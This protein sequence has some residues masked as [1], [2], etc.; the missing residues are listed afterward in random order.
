MTT[1]LAESK[2]VVEAPQWAA[3]R[4]IEEVLAML[5]H[6][7]RNPLSALSH[8]LEVWPSAQNDQVQMEELRSLMQRQMRQLIRLSNDLLDGARSARG[9]LTLRREHVCLRQ[10]IDDA[11]EEVRPFIDRCGHALTVGLPTSRS[12]CAATR[13]AYCRCL[14]I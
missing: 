10:L 11:C 3:D 4:R 7:I 2:S 14:R 1:L 12:W 6:E 13:R 8:A 9:E 5:G